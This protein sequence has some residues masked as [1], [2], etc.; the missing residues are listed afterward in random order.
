MA[1]VN[2][3]AAAIAEELGKYSAEVDE[4]MQGEID[5]TSKEIVKDLKNDPIIPEKTG[6]YKKSF[7]AKK[8]GQGKGYK[9]VV[10]ANKKYRLTH[11]LEKGHVT[12]NGGR[13][14]AF[15]HWVHAQEK[16]DTLAERI[17]GALT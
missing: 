13:T 8:L 4:A 17:K 10:V 5:K 12:R 9:R 11:L 14:R 3:L 2:N 16:A 6:D 15:P 1:D 7:Y